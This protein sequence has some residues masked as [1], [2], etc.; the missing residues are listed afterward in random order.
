MVQSVVT[1]AVTGVL[2]VVVGWLASWWR[3]GRRR[4]RALEAGVRELLLCKLEQLRAEM[5]AAGGIA[6]EDLK[7]RS[8]RIYDAYH[9]LDGN[10]H[11]T[12][13]NNDIQRAPIRPRE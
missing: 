9:G 3:G 2:G 12:A 7:S 5:V 11:G 6:D 4:D 13:I 10:G 8:Q 1:W